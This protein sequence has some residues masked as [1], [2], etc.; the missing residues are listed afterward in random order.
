MAE[1]KPCPFCGSPVEFKEIGMGL[2]KRSVIRCKSLDCYMGYP[3]AFTS[4]HNGDSTKAHA[5]MR[6]ATAW[7][8]RCAEPK[9]I[10]FDYEA[11]D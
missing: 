1:L 4:W 6:L 5:E 7:N 10:E 8:R 9:E 3:G 11:E 2:N